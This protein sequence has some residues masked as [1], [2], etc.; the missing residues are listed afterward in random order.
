MP[1]KKKYLTDHIKVRRYLN[2]LINEFSAETEPDV[3]R[4]RTLTFM[5]RALLEVLQF[6]RSVAIEERIIAIEKRLEEN[7]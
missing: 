6:E 4:Y 3:Q 7:T 2:Q 1:K 5:I